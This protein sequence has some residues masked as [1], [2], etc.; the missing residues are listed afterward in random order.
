MNHG[1]LW[2]CVF[3]VCGFKTSMPRFGLFLVTGLQNFVKNALLITNGYFV[4]FWCLGRFRVKFQ[5]SFVYNNGLWFLSWQG[6]STSVI[7]MGKSW[8]VSMSKCEYNPHSKVL[9]WHL[10]IKNRRQNQ[11]TLILCF[12]HTFCLSVN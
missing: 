7:I 8:S 2:S 10:P 12:K 1:L 6:N 3:T 5:D 9:F 4:I 11:R